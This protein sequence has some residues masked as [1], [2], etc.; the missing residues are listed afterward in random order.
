MARV[1]RA[2]DDSAREK[3]QASV[4]GL[5]DYARSFV[6]TKMKFLP[7]VDDRGEQTIEEEMLTTL[8]HAHS[9]RPSLALSYISGRSHDVLLACL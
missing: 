9:V 6:S 7:S 8:R 1:H 5:S 2:L 4:Q 3:A